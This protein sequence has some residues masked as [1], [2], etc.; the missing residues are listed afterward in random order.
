ML[1]RRSIVALGFAA[2]AL[3][4]GADGE[5]GP[6]PTPGASSQAYAVKVSVPGQADVATPLVSAPPNASSFRNSFAAKGVAT[7]ATSAGATTVIG[8]THAV[9]AAAASVASL[10]LF[11]GE[12]T[13]DA[14]AA[15]AKAGVTPTGAAGDLSGSSVSNLVAL[16]QKV[17]PSP[18]LR[19]QLAD[20]G[21]LTVLA[22]G[23][24]QSAP[25]G[26]KG[27]RGFVS[28]LD[29]HLNQAHGGLPAG[30]E[31]VV[32]YAEADARSAPPAPATTSTETTETTETLPVA[33]GSGPP[34]A[35]PGH[36]ATKTHKPRL[37][38]PP[39]VT[40]KLTAGGYVFPVY[41]PSSYV[42]TF[43]AARGDIVS[44]WH[45]GDDIFGQIGQ[46]LV[47]V[48][49]GTVFSVGW[50][51]VGGNRL[52]L[53]DGAGNEFYY[54]H[55]SAFSTLA[56]DGAHVEAGDVLG[57]MGNSGDAETTPYHLHFEIHPVS[58]LYRGYDGA[59]DPTTYLDGWRKLE[60]VN[61]PGGAAWAPLVHGRGGAPEPGAIL[62]QVSD[63]S[64]AAGLDPRSL[65]R[66][67]I[68]QRTVGG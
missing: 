44:G 67:R 11:G 26:G 9:A 5:A 47:A 2:L 59:V 56:V 15:S 14:V 27:F 51:R 64:Q 30:T 22:Q 57:F 1:L 68:A 24:D 17:E 36:V 32:G 8:D 53:R 63:I 41:G 61:F 46:P 18:D 38:R 12:I 16:G 43:G 54:A 29:V 20:W 33:P 65:R 23:I 42:D 25:A 6:R 35:Q 66:A 52:W 55:L 21:T 13:A 37:H 48:A 39:K 34:P 40:P 28:A 50:N 3:T 62:L 31:I 19:V 45:H 10:S 4:L 7:G 60:D 58:L 49:D